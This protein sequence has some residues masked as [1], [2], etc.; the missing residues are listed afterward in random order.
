MMASLK[1][2][3]IFLL[4]GT[5]QF[6]T[7]NSLQA[8]KPKIAIIGA[9]I[10]GSS[11]AHFLTKPFRNAEIHVF[12]K[13]VVGGR[14]SL[15]KFGN[16][17][18]E[19]GGAIIHPRN[20]YMQEFVKLLNLSARPPASV[21][22]RFGIWNGKELVFEESSWDTVTMLKLIYR[23]GFDP[24][25]LYR[26][27]NNILDDFERIY[28]FQNKGIGFD[29][30]T[31]LV[32]AMNPDF[33]N[34][35]QT[36]MEKH[37]TDLGYSSKLIKELV[38][39]T[40][41]VN[42]GQDID[43]HS[44]VASVSIAGAGFDLWSVKGGNKKVPE[45]LIQENDQVTLKHSAVKKVRKSIL[46]D[47]VKY[48]I[49]YTEIDKET[50]STSEY[51]IVIIAA[52]MTNDHF[53]SVIFEGFDDDLTFSGTYQT[54]I[55]TFVSGEVDFSYF[56]LDEDIQGIMSC[57]PEKTIIS[58]I[59][60]LSS[61]EGTKNPKTNIWKIFSRK[62]LNQTLLN[63]MFKNIEE[64]QEISWKAYPKYS[65]SLRLDKFKLDDAMYHVNAIEWAASAMEMSAIGGRN[66]AILAYNDYKRICSAVNTITTTTTAS[67][68]L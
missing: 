7:I 22:G 31:A 5:I 23:Y 38:E 62:K 43:V 11:A 53:S 8:C 15:V 29:N 32:Q 47:K 19:A 34:L 51:D 59:G 28:D 16:E 27:I 17:E 68:E 50:D 13:N 18:F 1:Y 6:K 44:F 33:I 21:G 24:I 39:A 10:G 48:E 61:V 25:Y 67:S 42:Y 64:I 55:A 2:W 36:P 9:G 30:V 45:K 40:L 3:Y 41:V 46:N 12:E 4:I 52:P 56:D 35:L 60:K 26:Y 65:S 58:S 37:L 14:L 57:E 54:T 20:K 66:V 63:K 49:T